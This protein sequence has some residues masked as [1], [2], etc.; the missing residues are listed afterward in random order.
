MSA[1]F[2]SFSLLSAREQLLLFFVRLPAEFI[3]QI[4]FSSQKQP[5]LPLSPPQPYQRV[6]SLVVSFCMARPGLLKKSASLLSVL[7]AHW[8][9]SKEIAGNDR[10][11]QKSCRKAAP[12]RP[13]PEQ[14]QS[15]GQILTSMTRN[16]K[17]VPHRLCCLELAIT[18]STV[19]GIPCSTQLIHLCSA[20]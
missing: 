6:G 18:F 8:I 12:S 17:L 4:L 5:L 19:S 11:H 9:I 2:S 3:F 15:A 16:R 14:K 20:P 10:H 1:W 7:P 13:A